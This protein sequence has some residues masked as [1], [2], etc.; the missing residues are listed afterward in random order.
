M[1]RPLFLK[2][3]SYRHRR[4]RDGARLLPVFG[5]F[6]VLLPILWA[7]AQTTMR[8]T[9]PDGIYLF[10]IWAVLIFAAAVIAPGLAA[11]SGDDAGQGPDAA[12]GED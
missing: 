9:A 5:A 7:P 2:R 3:Q 8:D 6:L 1:R 4:L 12:S 10:V 11:G